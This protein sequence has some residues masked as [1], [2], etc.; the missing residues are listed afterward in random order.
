MAQESRTIPC[1]EAKCD[2]VCAF[3]PHI[4]GV[5]KRCESC[6]AKRRACSRKSYRKKGSSSKK[7][8]IMDNQLADRNRALWEAKRHN[9]AL[10][11]KLIASENRAIALQTAFEESQ[12]SLTNAL[13]AANGGEMPL[14]TKLPTEITTR[15]ESLVLLSLDRIEGAIARLN[16]M[17]VSDLQEM[18]ER[19]EN[20][21]QMLIRRCG[22]LVEDMERSSER[23]HVISENVE[24]KTKIQPEIRKKK[25]SSQ[26]SL[27]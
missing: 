19:I 16:E 26:K 3:S 24:K 25:K 23:M 27:V 5:A 17:R 6:L 2:S 13:H 1:C 20:A 22:L 18:E 7:E 4:G 12:D 8:A 9:A 21:S 11:E 10:R 14:G 15:N